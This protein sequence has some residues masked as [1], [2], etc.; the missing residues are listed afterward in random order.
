MS[1]AT[2]DFY[3]TCVF[4]IFAV[5]TAKLTVRIRSAFARTVRALAI[6]RIVG[7]RLPPY[8]A[9]RTII[10]RRLSPTFKTRGLPS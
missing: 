1:A 5:L 10:A 6:S 4:D 2:G 8:G 3:N 7:H 9:V